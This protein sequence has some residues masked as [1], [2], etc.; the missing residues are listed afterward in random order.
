[1]TLTNASSNLVTSAEFVMQMWLSEKPFA[2][3]FQTDHGLEIHL[4][5]NRAL[6]CQLWW[7]KTGPEGHNIIEG[8]SRAADG[9]WGL[10]NMCKG[11]LY[12]PYYMPG[13]VLSVK[14]M[15]SLH[16]L[17]RIRGRYY[18]AHFTD[19][20]TEVQRHQLPCSSLY[21]I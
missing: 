3:F 12:G 19:G 13:T 18:Y 10:A 2:R 15:N 5:K 7:L 6:S 8:Q 9:G 1:M 17:P 20:K 21:P 11:H 14:C 4:Y 16:P